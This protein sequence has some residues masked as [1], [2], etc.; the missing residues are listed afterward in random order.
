LASGGGGEWLAK[1]EKR[2][3]VRG[4]FEELL[5]GG[6]GVKALAGG[7]AE[8]GGEKVR[9][10]APREVMAEAA[11]T[12]APEGGDEDEMESIFRTKGRK[13]QVGGGAWPALI[14]QRRDVKKRVVEEKRSEVRE[15]AVIDVRPPPSFYI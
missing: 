9:E 12:A 11:E 4:E 2:A 7:M 6:G 8:G 5:E 3:R 14:F 15:D 1:E 13:R 10:G